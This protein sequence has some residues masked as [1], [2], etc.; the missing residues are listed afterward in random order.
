MFERLPLLKRLQIALA[1]AFVTFAIV[2]GAL[3][4]RTALG[5]DPALG[6]SSQA[7]V[8][9]HSRRPRRLLR[10]TSSAASDDSYYE[11]DSA[12]ASGGSASTDNGT[13]AG[14]AAPR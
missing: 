14:R 6:R 13:T 4:V 10:T 1:I 11:D 5:K 7:H 9:Q 3:A 12:R 2:L 8:Q